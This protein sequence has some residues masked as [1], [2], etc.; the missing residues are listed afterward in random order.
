MNKRVILWLTLWTCLVFLTFAG[1]QEFQ[2]PNLT[3]NWKFNPAK[4][5]LQ[6]PP[7][8]SG[9]FRID[10]REPVFQVSRTFMYSGKPDE[11]S[12]SRTADGKEFVEKGKDR[13]TSGRLY[14]EG[15][16][17][18][19][20]E[21]IALKDRKATNVV[22]YEISPDGKTLTARESFRGPILKYD[23]IWV[24]DKQL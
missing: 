4:S 14:W 2:K 20:D 11:L 13:T 10:H 17:L 24:F 12:F 3:G 6:I 8:D 7:P 9:V 22:R 18:V 15:S 5:K 21:V 23:N 16:I 19:L 1:I